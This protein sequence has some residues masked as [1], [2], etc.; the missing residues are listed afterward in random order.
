MTPI[1]VTIQEKWRNEIPQP[2]FL[3]TV[4]GMIATNLILPGETLPLSSCQTLYGQ[5][6]Q[7]AI[8]GTD[9]FFSQISKLANKIIT[10]L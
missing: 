9:E 5:I 7:A 4:L 8:N 1:L 10:E 6:N 2:I 3:W